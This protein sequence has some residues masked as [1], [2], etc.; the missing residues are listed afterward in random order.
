MINKTKEPIV[1]LV[2]YTEFPIETVYYIWSLAKTKEHVLGVK[3]IHEKLSK[4]IKFKKEVESLFQEVIEMLLPCSRFVNFV[5]SLENITISL[6]EQLV[7]HKIGMEYWIQGARVTDMS[8]FYDQQEFRVPESIL[9]NPNANKLYLETMKKIQDSY[10][11]L[12]NNGFLF[13]EARELIP[14]GAFHRLSF[15]CNI[16]SLH[17]LVSKRTGWLLQ[18]DIWFPIIKGIISELE[19]NISPVFRSFAHPPEVDIKGNYIGYKFKDL[20]Y[21]RYIGVTKLPVDPI[22]YYKEQKY[23]IERSGKPIKKIEELKTEGLW[24]EE[25]VKEYI[26]LWGFNPSEL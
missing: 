26:D 22:F 1:R 9:N 15:T 16:E 11:Y 23:I 24:D 3:E 20:A 5:F 6:R 13:E 2:S 7:R 18:G 14:S 10:R 4:N 8:D 21:D 12:V 19:K 17:N 25:R